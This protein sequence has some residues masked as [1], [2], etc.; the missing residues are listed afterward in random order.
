MYVDNDPVVLAHA[1]ALLTSSPE[2]A[3]GY[4]EADLRDTA[5]VLRR[6]GD[7]L[8]FGKPLAILLVGVLHC[9]SDDDS[10]RAVVARLL[11]AAASGSYLVIAHPASD[12]D[13]GQVAAASTRLN[14]MMAEPVTLRGYLEVARLF[15]GLDLVEPGLVQLHRWRPG[16]EGPV[17]SHDIANYGG[18]GQK[19]GRRAR[20]RSAPA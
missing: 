7:V 13:A 2:G 6:A 16:P 5:T 14:E 10:P 11:A 1:R 20:R 12:I 8:D 3:T 17:P 18:V 15:V 19:A 9:I 4:V